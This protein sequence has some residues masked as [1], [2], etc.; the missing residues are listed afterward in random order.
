MAHPLEIEHVSVS[1]DTPQGEI[2]AVRDV[3]L[4]LRRGE[5]LALVGESGCGKSVLCK[6]AM[7]LLPRRA[8]IKAGR[9][10]ADGEDVARASER[11][12]CALR[13]RFFSMAFQNPLTALHPTLSVGAQ[14]AE[15]AWAHG[16]GKAAAKA[17]AAALLARVGI[18]RAEARFDLRPHYFSGGERQRVALAVALACRPQVLFADEITTALDVTVQTQILDLL[19]ELREIETLSVVFVSHD[20]G[21]VARVADRVA[22]L[23]AGRLVEI[24]TVEE[25][26]YDARHPYTWGLLGA[27]PA[28]CA[29]GEALSCIAGMPPDLLNPPPGD[30]FAAR[31]PYALRI[32]YEEAPPLFRI[33]E[34]HS[35]ATWLLDKR[36]PQV[37]PPRRAG[38][39]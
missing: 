35:A 5:I 28:L 22:V 26:F 39:S 33:S 25:I 11:R 1:F 24:G 36:A 8:R 31:N 34:T 37:A 14:I 2:E 7:R 10:L 4:T 15:A 3:S 32:D 12:M 29:R 18:R 30:A 27:H 23:Y 16:E 20:L 21:A 6:A 38:L 13:G 19:R 17:R 9:I